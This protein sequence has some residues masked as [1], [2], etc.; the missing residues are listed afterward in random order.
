[1]ET[2]LCVVSRALVQTQFP[3]AYAGFAENP[4]AGTAGGECIDIFP[5]WGA[6][7][8][9]TI[10]WW[11]KEEPF[12]SHWHW[13]I[14]PGHLTPSSFPCHMCGTTSPWLT[15]VYL[16][17]VCNQVS[18]L[19]ILWSRAKC[20]H[21]FVKCLLGIEDSVVL[22]SAAILEIRLSYGF[23]GP[24]NAPGK[25]E[26]HGRKVMMVDSWQ[27][28]VN[29]FLFHFPWEGHVTRF[30]I[31]RWISKSIVALLLPAMIYG[32][33]ETAPRISSFLSMDPLWPE[34]L[35]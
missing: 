8:I 15:A 34:A 24:W 26:Y 1:M 27:I 4:G 22:L 12:L 32:K 25:N 17:V 35:R 11:V 23:K 30:L 5:S 3:H 6:I 16:F 2:Y 28:A 13:S 14:R 18:S 33:S 7:I 20:L 9:I 19:L 10:T 21:F 29:S 31:P